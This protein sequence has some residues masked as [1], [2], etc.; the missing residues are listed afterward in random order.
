MDRWCEVS[1]DRRCRNISWEVADPNGDIPTW[2]R[3][4]IA[5]LMDIRDELQRLNRTLDCPNFQQIPHTLDAIRRNTAK[6]KP[7]KRKVVPR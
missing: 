5:V 3:I 4:S 6:K 2:E 7:L 1:V